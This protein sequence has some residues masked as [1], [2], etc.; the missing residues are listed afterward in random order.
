MSTRTSLSTGSGPEHNNDPALPAGTAGQ[1]LGVL[2][3]ALITGP[4]WGV[5]HLSLFLTE[6]GSRP[7]VSRWQPA[8][9]VASTIAFSLARVFN[10]TGE[11][12]PLAMLLHVS[13]N[14]CFSVVWS[15]RFP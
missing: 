2:P 5:R 10:R 3:G 7:D 1:P 9:F 6:W 4:L 15:E 14:N 11:S 12:L 13:V 8:E